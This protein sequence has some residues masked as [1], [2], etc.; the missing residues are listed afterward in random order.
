MVYMDEIFGYFPPTANPL[1]KTPLL[2]LLEAGTITAGVGSSLRRRILST[3]ITGLSNIG[4][5][6]G[7]PADRARDKAARRTR[8]APAIIRRSI[9][10]EVDIARV[11]RRTSCAMSTN[12]LTCSSALGAV[13]SAW[14]AQ[15]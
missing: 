12:G 5:V 14:T 8:K 11:S 10:A 15:P 3:S 13:V 9:R 4:M 1:S 7:P 6:A 2:T